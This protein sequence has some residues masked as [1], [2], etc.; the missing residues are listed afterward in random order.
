MVLI[1]GNRKFVVHKLLQVRCTLYQ[2]TEQ[3]SSSSS[4][5][6]ARCRAY[7]NTSIITR[8]AVL[9]EEAACILKSSM[10]VSTPKDCKV[11][12]HLLL[13]EFPEAVL[14]LLAAVRAYLC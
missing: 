3:Q 1:N 14:V 11:C 7:G 5:Y 13:P 2:Y 10:K 12:V 9:N 8:N 4:Y 6:R